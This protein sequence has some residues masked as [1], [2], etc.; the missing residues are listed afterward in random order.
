LPS[1]GRRSA[2]RAGRLCRN[3]PGFRVARAEWFPAVADAFRQQLFQG[4]ELV[5]GP[6]FYAEAYPW[7]DEKRLTILANSDAHDPVPPRDRGWLRPMT[8]IFTRSA[9]AAGVREALLAGRTA[10][11]MGGELWGP[12]DHLSGIWKGAVTIETPTLAGERS[13]F[14][15]MRVKNTS[16]IPFRVRAREAPDWFRLEPGT[17]EAEKTSLLRAQVAAAA[18]RGAT[19]FN[20]GLEI[21]NLHVGPGRN[22]MVQVPLTIEVRP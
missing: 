12:E 14:P 8:L 22:L 10:A 18:P 4:I 2:D 3:H 13:T 15:L 17:I 11:W 6:N 20:L 16:A 1:Y 19:P 21:T 7:I 5:N 9:D